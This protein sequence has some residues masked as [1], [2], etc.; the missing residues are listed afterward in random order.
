M[1]FCFSVLFLKEQK[2]RVHKKRVHAKK[3]FGKPKRFI[4]KFKN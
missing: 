1:T 2:N 4:T 3:R